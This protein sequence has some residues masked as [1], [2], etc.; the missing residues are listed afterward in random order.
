MH[1][2][3]RKKLPGMKIKKRYC[4]IFFLTVMMPQFPP[5]SAEEK[6][7]V[8]S[9]LSFDLGYIL[10][11]LSNNG[12]GFGMNYE[13]LFVNHF[14]FRMMAGTMI[15]QTQEKDI[16]S[17]TFTTSGFINYYPLSPTLDRL[18]IGLGQTIDYLNYFGNTTLPDPPTD[19]LISIGPT[20]G[21]KQNVLNLVMFDFY[22]N[23]N[24]LLL[25]TQ[26]LRNVEN[27]IRSGFRMGIKF[28]IF[29]RPW[30]DK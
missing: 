14:S 16:Y 2:P 10:L 22:A 3:P 27:Y 25:N 7:V 8:T 29:W 23:Y 11:G 6:K 21:W 15:F 17:A 19:V 13:R 28:K 4:F 30:S 1:N 24:F 18:Y 5:L 20:I 9:V 12:V 26:R